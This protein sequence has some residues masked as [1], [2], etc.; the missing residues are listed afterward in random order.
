MSYSRRR[1]ANFGRSRTGL[2]AQVGYTLSGAARVAGAGSGI[3]EVV[4]SPGSYAATIVFPDGF[5]GTLTWDT[6]GT[7]PRAFVEEINPADPVDL[8]QVVPVRVQDGVTAPTVGD[9]LLGAWAGAFGGR[10]EDDSHATYAIFGPAETAIRSFT[11]VI[12]TQ[13]NVTERH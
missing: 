3:A 1:V 6:G 11:L 4:G 9:A 8:A 12:D 7:T 5:A 10:I 13:G 2:A